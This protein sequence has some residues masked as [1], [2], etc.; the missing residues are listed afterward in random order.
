MLRAAVV[1]CG[2]IADSHAAQLARLPGAKLVA[3]CDREPLMVEQFCRRFAIEQQYTDVPALLRETRPDVIH[4][5]TP[6]A[7]H[8]S[9]AKLSLQ[10]GCHVYLEKPFAL[11]VSHATDLIQ[12]ATDMRLK[13]TAGHDDQFTPAARRLREAVK[14]GYLGGDPLHM[15]CHYGYHLRD[16]YARALLGDKAHWVRTL[17][18][19]LLQNIISHGIARLVEYL[20]TD[21]QELQ[22]FAFSSSFLRRRGETQLIDELR[23]IIR[24]SDVTAYF[25]FSTQIRPSLHEFRIFGPKNALVLDADQQTVIRLRGKTYTSYLEKFVK[26]A[27]IASQYWANIRHNARLFMRSEFHMKEGMKWLIEKFYKAIENDD[28]PPIPYREIVMNVRIMQQIIAQISSLENAGD[29]AA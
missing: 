15:E 2:K 1:G 5:T 6:P 9:L 21:A 4:I 22:A 10:H 11:R 25:T 7:T 17:P 12:M 3:A 26:P 16:G 13:I 28:A 19:G 24:D 20:P 14:S 8:Y 27:Q 23:V 18:G 29:Q